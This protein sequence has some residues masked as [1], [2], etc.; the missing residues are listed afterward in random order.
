MALGP[1]FHASPT[2]PKFEITGPPGIPAGCTGI[3]LPVEVEVWVNPTKADESPVCACELVP[4]AAAPALAP[5]F[6]V[7][8]ALGSAIAAV[9][10]RHTKI[11]AKSN[12]EIFLA[13]LFI[14]HYLL[15]FSNAP[16]GCFH[17]SGLKV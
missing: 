8:S 16:E 15:E 10:E 6:A 14:F 3:L 17:P 1:I 2:G 12:T 13:I 5:A 9:A 7:A 4:I 11:R